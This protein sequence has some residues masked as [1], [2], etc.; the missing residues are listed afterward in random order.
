MSEERTLGMEIVE[1]GQFEEQTLRTQIRV[2]ERESDK[3]YCY[4]YFYD[5]HINML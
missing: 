2:R 5:Y 4:F 3:V 1:S